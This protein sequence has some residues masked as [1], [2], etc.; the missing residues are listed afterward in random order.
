MRGNPDTQSVGQQTRAGKAENRVEQYFQLVRD[1][2]AKLP[3]WEFDSF[4]LSELIDFS[5][6]ATR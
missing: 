6:L 5:D 4:D 2:K 1:R 3:N